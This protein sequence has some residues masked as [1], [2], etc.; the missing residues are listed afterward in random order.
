M[1]LKIHREARQAGVVTVTVTSHLA[2]PVVARKASA[3]ESQLQELT[4]TSSK[5]LPSRSEPM[6][7]PETPGPGHKNAEEVPKQCDWFTKSFSRS[8]LRYNRHATD[9][10]HPVDSD[11]P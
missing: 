10:S 6:C 9:L 2:R 5:T 3:Q 8:A 1:A 4:A 11:K 7:D